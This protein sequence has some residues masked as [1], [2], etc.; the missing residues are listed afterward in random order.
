[1]Q[2]R[3]I[4]VDLG[5]TKIQTIALTQAGTPTVKGDGIH[6][7]DD[8]AAEVAALGELREGY[9]ITASSRR[10]TP[11]SG[12]P[13]A[14]AD[15]VADTV[16]TVGTDADGIG[17]GFAGLVNSEK[18]IV[19]YGT[20]MADFP[21]GTPFAK[22]VSERTGLPTFIDND[23]NV[24]ALGEF[25]LGAGYGATDMMGVW[26]GTGIGAG[27]ILDGKVRR[28][29]RGYAAEVGHIIVRFGGREPAGGPTGSLEAYAG[30]ASMEKTARAWAAKG[31]K[32]KLFAI[33]EAKGK[34]RFTSGVFRKAVRKGDKVAKKLMRDNVKALGAGLASMANALDLD[35]FVVGGG[36][37]ESFG[38]DYVESVA[39]EMRKS[40]IAPNYVPGVRPA[41]LGDFSGAIGASMV[42]EERLS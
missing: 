12:G 5:G 26:V 16:R 41:E 32:T 31:K 11:T 13:D 34:P 9:R 30:R 33:A 17:I 27:I 18:G 39:D 37:A 3:L 40:L 7:P 21:N 14:I 10:L 29:P 2:M 4:G 28:G 19:S 36:I 23:V 20:N 35:M 24:A 42:V 1:M 15:E 25:R 38:D 6:D 22:L 8:A